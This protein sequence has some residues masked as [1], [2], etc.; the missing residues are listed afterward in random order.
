M[1]RR[2]AAALVVDEPFKLLDEPF[3]NRSRGIRWL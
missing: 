3:T 1:K 2:S